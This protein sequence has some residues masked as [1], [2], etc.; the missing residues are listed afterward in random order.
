MILDHDPAGVVL[1]P[2]FL[3]AARREAGKAQ[4]LEDALL[5]TSWV[6]FPAGV[7]QLPGKH[8]I[9]L[10]KNEKYDHMTWVLGDVGGIFGILLRFLEGVSLDVV[11]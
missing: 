11:G 2:T 9:F 1:E 7:P 10:G 6:V 8:G 5:E 3:M 4:R